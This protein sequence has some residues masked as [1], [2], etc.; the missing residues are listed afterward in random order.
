MSARLAAGLAGLALSAASAYALPRFERVP[1]FL[2]ASNAET[3]FSSFVMTDRADVSGICRDDLFIVSSQFRLSGRC[4][5]DLWAMADDLTLAGQVDDHARLGGNKLAVEGTIAN[6]LLAAGKAVHLSTGSVV[7]GG[8]VLAAESAI[9]GG[10]VAGGLRVM[11]DQCTL[12]G[13]V[14][15]DVQLV[16]NDIVIMPG[17]QIDGDLHYLSATELV[18][19]QRVELKGKLIRDTAPLA[20]PAER[21]P[22]RDQLAAQIVYLAAAWVSG[23]FL[24]G[25]FPGFASRAV[26][27]LRGAPARCGLAGAIGFALI[28]MLAVAAAVTLI[29]LPVALLLGGLYVAL[30]YLGKIAVA[31]ALGAFLMRWRGPQS[32]GRAALALLA[33]LMPVYLSALVPGVGSPLS[34]LINLLGLG[35]LLQALWRPAGAAATPPPPPAAV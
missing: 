28:P 5:N 15:G 11:A 8:A 32:F 35:A 22:L 27:S 1:E 13:Q 14:E 2:V 7:R 17:T 21:P 20:S 34:M 6:G 26:V 18:L 33:G 29:G 12:A 4:A 19:D 9:L 31:L 3:A 24:L 10:H 30:L 16:A 25:V 23:L